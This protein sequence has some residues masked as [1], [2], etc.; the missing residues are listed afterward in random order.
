VDLLGEPLARGLPA[1][2]ERQRDEVPR[3]AAG[4]S[5]LDALADLG[6]GG[7]SLVDRLRDRSQV[8]R[9]VDLDGAGVQ[10]LS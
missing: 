6:L 2:A 7:A 10:L 5:D 1:H 9:V 3:P 4:A 8:G